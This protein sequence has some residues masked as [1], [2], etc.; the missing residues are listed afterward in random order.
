MNRTVDDLA[1][2]EGQLIAQVGKRQRYENL[3]L[4]RYTFQDKEASIDELC[5]VAEEVL[6]GPW[7]GVLGAQAEH[8]KSQ[9]QK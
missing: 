4:E 5:A 7:L 6:N 3:I 1:K 2:L 8:V 9:R